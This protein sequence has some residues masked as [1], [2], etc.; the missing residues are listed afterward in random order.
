MCHDGI[1]DLKDGLKNTL[2]RFVARGFLWRM[3]T[4]G[5]SVALINDVEFRDSKVCE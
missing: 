5:Y 1:N 3:V 2:L 4:A